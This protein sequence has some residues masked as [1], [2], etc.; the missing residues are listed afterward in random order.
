[1]AITARFEFDEAKHRKA[2]RETWAL[3]PMRWAVLAGGILVPATMIWIGV[4]RHWEELS[5]A[6][7]FT[8]ALPWLLLGVFFLG[9]APVLQRSAA[10]KALELD[11]SLQGTQERMLDDTGLH[12]RGAG[13]SPSLGWGELVRVSETPNFFLFFYDKNLVHYIPKRALDGRSRDEL[14][15]LIQAH[16]P[17]V[18]RP[19]LAARSV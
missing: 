7:A 4:G 8:N 12:V 16:A 14:R 13:F 19:A 17:D 2:L 11:P 1:M 5:A 3:N 9:L 6:D 15:N 18:G 10:R